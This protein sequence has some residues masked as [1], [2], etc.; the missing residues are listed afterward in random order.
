ME[1]TEKLEVK[2]EKKEFKKPII[3]ET[4]LI[5]IL[6][7]DIPGD[8]S[9]YIG[10]MEI[11]GISWA[12]SNALCRKLNI[13]R[14]KKIEDLKE[15]EIKKI[16]DF[17]KNPELP[18]YLMNRRK[19]FETGNTRHL[20]GADLDLQKDFDIKRLKKIKSYK[21]IRHSSGQP[22]RGQ[23]TKAHF[24]SN[25]KK[26]G[27]VGVKKVKEAPKPKADAKGGKKK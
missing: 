8:K 11:K 6:S 13:S 9:V 10:I 16:S 27:A 4:K 23:S 1:K 17:I 24:R 26:T 22:V 2:Q 20:H 19:E 15:E 25:R 7:K 14:D 12:F 18:A 3:N 5:R 21:G